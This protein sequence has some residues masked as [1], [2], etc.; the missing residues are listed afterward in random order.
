MTTVT[1]TMV[2]VTKR[3]FGRCVYRSTS[4]KYGEKTNWKK[5][6]IGNRVFEWERDEKKTERMKTRIRKK[7]HLQVHIVVGLM[8][9]EVQ[10]AQYTDKNAPHRSCQVQKRIEEAKDDEL[11]RARSAKEIAYFKK[12]KKNSN[13][14]KFAM[15][16]ICVLIQRFHWFCICLEWLWSR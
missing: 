14:C 7:R 8:Q 5:K 15:K 4:T 6:P 3:K 9:R 1:I 10:S 11:A 13:F 12:S 2:V 16:R